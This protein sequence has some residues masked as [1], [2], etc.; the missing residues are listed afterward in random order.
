MNCFVCFQ[1][2]PHVTIDEKLRNLLKATP[3]EVLQY[4]VIEGKLLLT[5]SGV[6][7]DFVLNLL[8]ACLFEGTVRP[9]SE[10]LRSQSHQ[11]VVG[12]LQKFTLKEH[13]LVWSGLSRSW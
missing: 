4:A 2:A 9:V 13:R 5:E 8:S 11:D 7:Q 6:S 3:G 1:S 10:S 12:V